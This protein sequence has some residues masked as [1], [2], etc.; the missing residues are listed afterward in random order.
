MTN[1]SLTNHCVVCIF[2]IV[3]ILSLELPEWPQGCIHVCL[4]AYSF[5]FTPFILQ[6]Y[7]PRII[8]LHNY[9]VPSNLNTKQTRSENSAI[10]LQFKTN[11]GCSGS[12]AS[13]LLSLS[14][15]HTNVHT[16]LGSGSTHL[17]RNT[18]IQYTCLLI[19][20]FWTELR[21]KGFYM[22]TSQKHLP[23]SRLV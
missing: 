5:N 9:V 1:P 3:F 2:C 21:A 15:T 7:Y 10:K 20:P 14:H 4:L 11:Y 12:T 13:L 18:N 22:T 19:E 8:S 16:Q 17:C 6:S 23:R